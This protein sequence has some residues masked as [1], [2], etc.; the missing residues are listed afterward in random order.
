[1]GFKNEIDEII[2]TPSLKNAHIGVLV[3][4]DEKIIYELNSE[5]L[6]IP[7]SNL[8]LFTSATILNILQPNF[9]IE[10][11]FFG[12]TR[13]RGGELNG[14]LVIRAG[15]DPTFSR[16]RLEKIVTGLSKK[17][18]KV[19]EGVILDLSVFDKEYVNPYWEKE[20]LE[21]SYAPR[22]VPFTLERGLIKIK[23]YPTELGLK[24]RIIVEPFNGYIKIENNARTVSGKVNQISVEKKPGENSFV[25]KGEI[26]LEVEEL[27]FEKPIEEPHLYATEYLKHLMVKHGIKVKGEVREGVFEDGVLLAMDISRPLSD[28]NKI[29]L[30][31]SDNALA[32]YFT[33]ILG[34]YELGEGSWIKGLKV[35]RSYLKQLGIDV[36]KLKIVDGSGLSRANR[37]TP[38]IIVDFL[39]RFQRNRFFKYF[40]TALPV[41][42]IDGTLRDRMK[43]TIA[44]GRIRAK[45]GTLRDVVALSGYAT[46]LSGKKAFFSII[47][48]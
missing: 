2:K 27:V 21:H 45:T 47:I 17:L 43:N 46:C 4:T 9:R 26:G 36:T 44:E 7:A 32:E 48:N 30:K 35:M 18:R 6:F 39:K 13:V 5:D 8:K 1:M 31:F 14:S 38:R 15:G 12:T 41:A 3:E 23:V 25:V 19:N 34:Y 11:W 10:T 24:P 22:I 40:Y 33:K 37:V 28:L 42:G 29:L 20:D 16:T